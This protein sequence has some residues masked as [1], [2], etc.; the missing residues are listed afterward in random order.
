MYTL[1]TVCT[2]YTDIRIFVLTAS[3]T[4]HILCTS[5]CSPCLQWVLT[6]VRMY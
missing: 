6:Y 5:T 3:I 4:M 2:V 1:K